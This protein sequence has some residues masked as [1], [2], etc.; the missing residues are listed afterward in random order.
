M[1]NSL[2]FCARA[3]R[4]FPLRG[5]AQNYFSLFPVEMEGLPKGHR[6]KLLGTFCK[7]LWS[8]DK[9]FTR[10][11]KKWALQKPS[12]TYYVMTNLNKVEHLVGSLKVAEWFR[13]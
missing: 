12:C 7:A 10:R 13:K 4:I 6:E 1:N 2:V 5:R 3:K 11:H 8:K 9:I